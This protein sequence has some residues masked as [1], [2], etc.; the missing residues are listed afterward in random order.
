VDLTS[1]SAPDLAAIVGGLLLTGT[2]LPLLARSRRRRLL[3]RL[4]SGWR[5]DPKGSP[6]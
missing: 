4:R 2:V 3:G 1:V 5:R 6:A